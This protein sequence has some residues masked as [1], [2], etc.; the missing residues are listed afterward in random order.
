[1]LG[2]V[3][4]VE[5]DAHG[6]SAALLEPAR[7][8]GRD[9]RAVGAEHRAQALARRISHEV[10]NVGAHER[11]ATREDHNF[12]TGSGNL[13]DKRAGL[14]GRE[15]VGARVGARVL[16]AML[17][18]EVALVGGHPG[19]DHGRLLPTCLRGAR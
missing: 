19:Y 5:A 14:V 17:A 12:E 18:G 16:V 3:E 15:L 1:M 11:L 7:H 6:A 13:V 9:E 8:F 2:A 10:V 4:A